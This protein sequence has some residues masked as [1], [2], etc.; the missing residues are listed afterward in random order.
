M[1]L[2]IKLRQWNKKLIK[3]TARTRYITFILIG[4]KPREKIL[5]N[6]KKPCLKFF[7]ISTQERNGSQLVK[8]SVDCFA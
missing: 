3:L 2:G 5:S 7:G 4:K 6:G 1:A 8:E